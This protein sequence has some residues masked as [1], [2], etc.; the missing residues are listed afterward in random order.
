MDRFVPEFADRIQQV[1]GFA[2]ML[3]GELKREAYLLKGDPE[4]G[5][6]FLLSQ[7]QYMAPSHRMPWLDFRDGE[8]HTFLSIIQSAIH[9]LGLPAFPETLAEIRRITQT[10]RHDVTI[11]TENLQPSEGRA[12]GVTFQVEKDIQIGGDVVGRDKTTYNSTFHLPP[13]DTNQQEVFKQQISSAFFAELRALTAAQPVILTYDSYEQAPDEAKQWMTG[14]LLDEIARGGLPG[15][16]VI[17]A[18]RTIPD[19]AHM[20]IPHTVFTELQNF[21]LDGATEYWVTC[22]GLPLET[23]QR[24]Y[25]QTRGHPKELAA[26][27][28]EAGGRPMEY[29]ILVI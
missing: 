28:N 1:N 14:L 21:D 17:I 13:S 23:L 20:L 19:V 15:V 16:L 27:A 22:R 9:D 10:L 4:I 26:R 5:K 6:S 3:T 18:G 8:V 25:E 12:G 7:F 29:Q 2:Q 24:A 11:R